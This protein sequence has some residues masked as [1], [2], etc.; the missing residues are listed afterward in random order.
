M[1]KE[2]NLTKEQIQSIDADL[3]KLGVKYWDLRIELVD[4]IVLDIEKRI[5]EEETFINAWMNAKI[6][7]GY[8]GDFKEFVKKRIKIHNKNQL[9]VF[10]RELISFFTSKEVVVFLSLLFV[11][12][13]ILEITVVKRVVY[14]LFSGVYV[15]VI[16]LGIF[17]WK[18][19]LKSLRLSQFLSFTSG[20]FILASNKLFLDY[21]KKKPEEFVIIFI[22]LITPLIYCSV[23]LFLKEYFK[24]QKTYKKYAAN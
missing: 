8:N 14:W 15:S 18:F 3:I 13:N 6:A 9:Q 7:L 12:Y 21:L 4:H 5:S 24:Y 19:I 20:L 11:L 23:K 1:E 22:L 17:R 2:K 10:K 16:L